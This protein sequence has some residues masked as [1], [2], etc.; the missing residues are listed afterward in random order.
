ME[1]QNEINTNTAQGPTE[2]PITKTNWL[3]EEAKAIEEN[4]FD[5]EVLPSLK[6]EE[7]KITEFEVDFSEPFQKWTG[8]DG[9]V[10][11]I[12]PVMHNGQRMNVWLSVRNPLYSKLIVAGK[13]GQTLFKVF[14]TGQQKNT[15]Y[16]LVTD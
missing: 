3:E 14:R 9:V 5:G 4:K 12:I 10:K 1:Q 16:T 13:N 7:G 6:F 8:E 15:R 2:E 11:K